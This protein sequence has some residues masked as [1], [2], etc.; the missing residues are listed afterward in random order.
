MIGFHKKLRIRESA[1]SALNEPTP[2]TLANN[3]LD[4][5]HPLASIY[6][7]VRE[8]MEQGA[9]PLPSQTSDKK[10]PWGVRR[11]K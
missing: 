3:P 2:T 11:M 7:L 6:Y 1:G 9:W 5:F 10:F 8:K 4:A